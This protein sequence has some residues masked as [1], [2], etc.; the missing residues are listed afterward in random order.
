M[1]K[2]ELLNNRVSVK[3]EALKKVRYWLDYEKH[4]WILGGAIGFMP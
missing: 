4:T 2:D 1:D 3:E